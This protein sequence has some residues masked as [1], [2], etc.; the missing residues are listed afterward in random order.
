MPRPSFPQLRLPSGRIRSALSHLHKGSPPLSSSPD[1]RSL[2]IV[3]TFNAAHGSHLLAE[4]QQCFGGTSG[5]SVQGERDWNTD[6]STPVLEENHRDPETCHAGCREFRFGEPTALNT[7]PAEGRKRQITLDSAEVWELGSP[8][9]GHAVT[10][11][12]SLQAALTAR[13]RRGTQGLPLFSA[14]AGACSPVSTGCRPCPRHGMRAKDHV[15][16]ENLVRAPR[17]SPADDD[18]SEPAHMHGLAAPGT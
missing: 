1:S 5:S 7:W 11:P 16:R 12:T 9:Q 4:P 2:P 15:T 13:E 8:T 10:V 18:V 3:T 6:T 14:P 17:P